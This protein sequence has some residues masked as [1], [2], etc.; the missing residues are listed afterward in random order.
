[1]FAMNFWVPFSD[2]HILRKLHQ[3]FL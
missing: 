1:V 3:V 2:P